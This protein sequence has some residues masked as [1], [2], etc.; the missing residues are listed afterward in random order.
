VRTFS[1]GNGG[2]RRGS[3]TVP[4]ANDTTKSGTTVGEAEGC[5]W[6]L[7]VE[8]DQRKLDWWAEC[9]VELNCRLVR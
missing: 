5:G 8:D 9:T 3:S 4:E 6:R 1:E 7:K 2:R